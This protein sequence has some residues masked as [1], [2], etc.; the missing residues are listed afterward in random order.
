VCRWRSAFRLAA[1]S[2]EPTR[3]ADAARRRDSAGA[4]VAVDVTA[5]PGRVDGVLATIDFGALAA[6]AR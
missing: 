6:L 2:R 4:S 3:N 5:D 1:G